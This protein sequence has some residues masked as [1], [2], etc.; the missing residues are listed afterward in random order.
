MGGSDHG[1]LE[2]VAELAEV[3]GALA[4]ARA[5]LGRLVVVEGPPGIGKSSLLAAARAEAREAG[6]AVLAARGGVLE[7]PLAHGVSRSLFER[8]L[9]DEAARSRLLAGSAALAA[10]AVGAPSAAGAVG[11][12]AFA[13]L[14]GLYW[15]TVNLAAERPLLLCVDDVHWADRPSLAFLEY[16]ARRLDELPVCLLTGL[17]TGDP[18][19]DPQA[20]ALAA[21]SGAVVLQPAALS[22]GAVEQ[23][24]RE[25]LEAAV[26][27]GFAA[28]CHRATGGNPFLVRELAGALRADGT[29][30]DAAAAP[31]V[32]ALGPRTVARSVLLRL[33][34]LPPA[35]A[36]LARAGAVLE[37]GASL[38][39]VAAVAGV[40]DGPAAEALDALAAIEILEGAAEV[41]FVHP[42]VRAAVY[43]DLGP[44]ARARLH[45]RAAEVLAAAGAPAERVAPHLL[46]VAPAGEAGV[47]ETLR[48]AA[49]A[50][51][52]RGAPETATRLLERALDEPPQD[53]ARGAVLLELG[54]AR[55]QTG[56]DPSRTIAELRAATD[57]LA[58]D[59]A[60]AEAWLLL[61]RATM[62]SVGVVEAVDVWTEALE[63]L[64][65]LDEERRLRMAVERTNLAILY[66]ET[67]DRALAW[68]GE[69]PRPDPHTPGG[70]L[71]GCAVARA[72]WMRGDGAEAAA[73][74]ALAALDGGALLDQ[75]GP[76][77]N[78]YHQL[79]YQLVFCDR[80]DEAR[81][82]IEAAL[83]R[84]RLVGSVWGFTAAST[85]RAVVGYQSGALAE[86][87]ADARSA[88][89]VPHAPPW[90]APTTCAFLALVLLERDEVEAAE[91]ALRRG[92][93]GPE[94]AVLEHMNTLF[95]ARARVHAARGAW[96]AALEDAREYGRRIEE[97]N[98]ALAP[99]VPWRGVAA[100]ALARMGD[101]QGARELVE[102][103]R[104]LAE[105]WGTATA[106]GM[107]LHAAGL[108]A[109][110]DE[111]LALLEAAVAIQATGPARL[112]H[113][114]AEVELGAALRRRGQRVEARERLQA[115]L[116]RAR[117]CGA[118]RLVRQAHE[119][120][121]A[122]GARPRRLQF[123]GIEAL[124]ASER[125]IAGLA[126]GGRTNR[127]IAEAL[128]VTPKTVENHLGRVYGKLGINSRT[129]LAE[130]LAAAGDA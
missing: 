69:L 123:S 101:P 15:L 122:A 38:A 88:L 113:A 94:L 59:E 4:D 107:A 64:R 22:R 27:G 32:A 31:G 68:I 77:L 47:V 19:T 12:A 102:R 7:R 73:E 116:D 117:R 16:L 60:R 62:T 65:G 61:A 84:A 86:A 105:R 79:P 17:R 112:E 53:D 92:G 75:E 128:F 5:G 44:A 30:P 82:E 21:G 70:R 46:E 56:A 66:P 42:L 29:T 3:A 118:T 33:A 80:H 1:L 45:R 40:G 18:D 72:A 58:G 114:R 124:T 37:D 87:E 20:L 24:L 2:R 39:T 41:R 78:P 10:E 97:G 95:Y 119:E 85:L 108:V 71:V 103:Q 121:V 8:A 63:A 106:R 129:Q 23:L 96:E 67:V 81:A 91:A 98:R 28:E 76:E 74:R 115:G 11:D 120:L 110:G 127:E 57:A 9:A 50:A 13:V 126:A 34:S 109:E 90:V 14:H 89:D 52:R 111:A 83:D 48:A 130:L 25:R 99:G 26:D 104:E 35:A 6:M 93:C 43:G 36:D 54:R 125:R 100:L 51:L 55:F 49:A